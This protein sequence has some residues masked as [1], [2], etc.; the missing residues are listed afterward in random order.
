MLYRTIDVFSIFRFFLVLIIGVFFFF[1]FYNVSKKNFF[2][3][4]A[5][6]YPSQVRLDNELLRE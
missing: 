6:T 1:F 5:P 2:A 4:P 3:H